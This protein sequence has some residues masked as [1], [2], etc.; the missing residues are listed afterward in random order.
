MSKIKSDSLS[1]FIETDKF[2]IRP[3][4]K[5]TSFKENDEVD[6]SYLQKNDYLVGNKEIWLASSTLEEYSTMSPKT[7]ITR[8]NHFKLYSSDISLIESKLAELSS[9]KEVEKVEVE[10]VEIEEKLIYDISSNP[11]IVETEKVKVVKPKVVKAK[12]TK[13]KEVKTKEVKTKEVK[14][15][16][17]KEKKEEKPIKSSKTKK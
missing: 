6:V 1:I 16:A 5:E 15:K 2:I 17:V 11:L 13:T 10:E 3:N 12:V 14:T 8:S 7:L 9:E 4:Y